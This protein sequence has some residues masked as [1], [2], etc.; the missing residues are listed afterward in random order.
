M[1]TIKYNEFLDP[2]P[3]MYA[4]LFG[5]DASYAIGGVVD[6][7]TFESSSYWALTLSTLNHSDTLGSVF[8]T[9]FNEFDLAIS[10]DIHGA[11]QAYNCDNEIELHRN[12]LRNSETR[13]GYGILNFS[14]PA[15]I[16]GDNSEP[17]ELSAI[18][19]WKYGLACY[20]MYT[21]DP[22]Y[23]K[24]REVAIGDTCCPNKYG[25]WVDDDSHCDLGTSINDKGMNYLYGEDVE[26]IIKWYTV[27]NS[28]TDTVPA[29]GNF[30][31]GEGTEYPWTTEDNVDASK[32][33]GSNPFRN[34][35]LFRIGITDE[36]PR[37][38]ALTQNY[39]N[40]FNIETKIQFSLAKSSRVSI[41]IYNILGQRIRD[42]MDKDLPTGTHQISWNG[43]DDYG[44]TVATG[45]Y[46]Y[47]IEA[48]DLVE[49]KKM[50]LVK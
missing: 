43:R 17:K 14:T 5:G 2:S 50:M 23:P 35:E 28:G 1:A 26:E 6:S 8:K 40:P 12:I 31:T 22:G 9:Q 34:F 47:R 24:V 11:I 7:N 27:Y 46:F 41:S 21:D 33:L 10:S 36:T 20:G 25:V 19:N 38:G 37:F 39:P 13:H 45:I 4:C 3:Y 18:N 42:I 30:W 49:T 16:T 44:T 15:V 48:D 29:Q 32:P